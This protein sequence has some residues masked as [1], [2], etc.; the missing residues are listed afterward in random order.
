MRRSPLASTVNRT[1]CARCWAR[2]T[3][4]G[5][6]D[7]PPPFPPPPS[8]DPR[9]IQTARAATARIATTITRQPG[10]GS[11][12]RRRGGVS[13]GEGTGSNCRQPGGRRAGRSRLGVDGGGD[14]GAGQASAHGAAV[15]LVREVPVSG[16]DPRGPGL[17]L[18]TA[19]SPGAGED[20]RPDRFGPRRPRPP[21]RA[22]DR[23]GWL[24]RRR[25]RPRAWR[26]RAL[27]PVRARALRRP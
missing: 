3:A 13:V 8:P 11:L 2:T 9:A 20:P 15:L 10:R 22:R 6:G 12:R 17:T 26:A 19:R 16:R 23:G 14:G 25:R 5:G 27:R 24:D 21:R 7:S 1:V 4:L 18:A